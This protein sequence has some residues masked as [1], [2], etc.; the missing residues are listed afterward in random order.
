MQTQTLFDRVEEWLTGLDVDL[1]R[2]ILSNGHA[3][4]VWTL[5]DALLRWGV[6]VPDGVRDNL[7]AWARAQSDLGVL[8]DGRILSVPAVVDGRTFT[9]THPSH[10]GVL[11]G[12]D[13]LILAR[14]FSGW[15]RIPVSYAGTRGLAE[16]VAGGAIRW[17]LPQ[18]ILHDSPR[19]LL[20]LTACPD[21][22]V[23]GDVDAGSVSGHRLAQMV[24]QSI[25]EEGRRPS[26]QTGDTAM[27]TS[28]SD[29]LMTVLAD[30]RASRAR[31]IA[32]LQDV[33][34]AA[35][36]SAWSLADCQ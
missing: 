29:V 18:G 28:W 27:M 21:G 5:C 20:G 14:R 24:I 3:V 12:P 32:P 10:A 26:T 2:R 6:A 30:D 19:G 22:V 16:V 25:A 9:M 11:G 36:L 23:L 4:S 1:V 31:P 17:V 15:D 8:P 13:L 7:V 35:G 34:L 33:L